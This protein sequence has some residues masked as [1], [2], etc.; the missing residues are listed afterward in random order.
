[1]TAMDAGW[2]LGELPEE[3][4]RR[5]GGWI[6]TL[7]TCRREDEEFGDKST[8]HGDLTPEYIQLI[9]IALYYD[10]WADGGNPGDWLTARRDIRSITDDVDRITAIRPIAEILSGKAGVLIDPT[11]L[12]FVDQKW[13]DVWMKCMEYYNASLPPRMRFNNEPSLQVSKRDAISY[14]R[15]RDLDEA[16]V[17]E[18]RLR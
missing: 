13:I 12:D 1:M 2:N 14:I 18:M 8:S 6:K 3:A 16:V 11:V 10:W 17:A 4:E 9:K 15:G 5:I 7:I